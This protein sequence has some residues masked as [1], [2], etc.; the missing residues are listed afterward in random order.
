MGEQQNNFY[1]G[2]V[3]QPPIKQNTI[4]TSGAY[5]VENIIVKDERS[6]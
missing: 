1:A 6:I 4:N 2:F 5:Y 3:L